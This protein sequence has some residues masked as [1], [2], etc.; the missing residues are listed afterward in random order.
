MSLTFINPLGKGWGFIVDWTADGSGDASEAIINLN[1]KSIETI[2]IKPV[3]VSQAYDVKLLDSD[4]D[5]WLCDEGI[6][7]G[8]AETK[9]IFARTKFT[10]HDTITID[11][12]GANAG[13]TG[14]III[15]T[16]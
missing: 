7:V 1:G 11:I 12:S 6:A 4:S 8:A 3:A 9:I 13:A 16:V 5:D 15:Y 10:L 14:Q 2:K